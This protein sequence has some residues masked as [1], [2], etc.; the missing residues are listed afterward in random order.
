MKIPASV[1]R[2]G[3]AC[4]LGSVVIS[5]TVALGE[6]TPPPSNII[7]WWPGEGSAADIFSTNHG[8]VIGAVSFRGGLVGS[9]IEITGDGQYILLP[10]SQ[11]LR[12]TTAITIEGW[13]KPMDIDTDQHILS[14]AGGSGGSPYGHDYYLRLVNRGLEFRINDVGFFVP[15]V[16]TQTNVW[17]HIAATYSTAGG[18]RRLF[19]NGRMVG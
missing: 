8:T 3:Y 19:V 16:I 6:C 10:N 1:T 7:A 5:A 18:M 4:W 15:N 2:L 17:Y 11:S 12:L 13:V 9:A 14:T